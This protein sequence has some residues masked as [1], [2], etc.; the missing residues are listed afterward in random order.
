[1]SINYYLI[2]FFQTFEDFLSNNTFIWIKGLFPDEL[3]N[4][5]F[6]FSAMTIETLIG[7][8]LIFIL[9]GLDTS[10][11]SAAFALYFLSK[12][13]DK[14]E[15]LRKELQ[16]LVARDGELNYHN[17]AEASYLEGVMCESLRLLPPAT[18]NERICSQSFRYTMYT[19][20]TI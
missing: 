2:K 4:A 18:F 1:M 3:Y 5:E 8:I 20:D 7:Q 10:G 15:K 11:S 19:I 12:H 17:V 16:G 14:Q 13:K 9:A 6:T